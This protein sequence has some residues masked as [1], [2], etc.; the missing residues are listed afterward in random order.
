MAMN[1]THISG[2]ASINA[3]ETNVTGQN[4]TWLSSGLLPGDMFWAAGLMVRIASI[5]DN[6][7][8]T[9]AAA[10]PGASRASAQYEIWRT[11]D[12]DRMG[13]TQ[14]AFLDKLAG[15]LFSMADL[16]SAADK[17][18]YF[19]GAGAMGLTDLKQ[20]GRSILA[21]PTAQDGRFLGYNGG[22]PA[23]RT[24]A[25]AWSDLGVAPD[26]SLPPGLRPIATEIIDA[27]L[28]LT[29]GLYLFTPGSVNTPSASGYWLYRVEAS[30]DGYVTQYARLYAGDSPANSQIVRR[31]KNAGT[32]TGYTQCLETQVELDARY[33]TKISPSVTGDLTIN[34]S[35]S[36][37]E[38][39]QINLVRGSAQTSLT[40]VVSMDTVSRQAR[41][42]ATR[43]SDGAAR[44]FE[45]DF[46]SGAI[47]TPEGA[48]ATGGMLLTR[49]YTVQ[50]LPTPG[51][52][53]RIARTV[54]GRAFTEAGALEA[55]GSGT[56]TLVED[57]GFVWRVAGRNVTVSA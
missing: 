2:T 12:I 20:T 33:V 16:N 49:S 8:L 31:D 30:P 34:P 43:A 41:I 11:P 27:N 37:P 44:V 28:A 50:T 24:P 7:H 48:I 9:L 17:L 21:L 32:W 26:S 23:W 4:S 45:L 40:G 15:N 53:G 56:G 51:I 1:V 18:P 46:I 29:S 6:T 14:R 52:G 35:A 38:G 39:G 47:S 22:G 5:Q 3:G 36:S 42:F 25:Q 19:I 10:W 54:N 13:E 55:S 57:N